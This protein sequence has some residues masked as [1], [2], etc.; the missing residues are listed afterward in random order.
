MTWRRGN[1]PNDM[2][3][4]INNN[5]PA[6]GQEF[7]KELSSRMRIVTQHMQ[8][9]LDNDVAGGG[10]PFTGKSMYFN[11]RKI[12][13]Y[14]TVNQII[15]L[16]NQTSYLKFILDPAYRHVNERKIIPY[17]NAKLTKQ[18]NITQ[19]RS[20]TQ[21]DKYKKVKSRNGNTY[22]IDATKKSSKRN[23]KLAR[24]QRVIGYY[25]S[26]G[27]KTLFDFYDE[28]EKKVIEQLRTL[29]G[30]FDYRWRN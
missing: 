28:T 27:R 14:K 18:G 12:S 9:K 22:L 8:R 24:E 4:F 20:R 29:R 23:P 2:R 3:R 26:V 11:F 15:V 10:V 19:L 1:S 5:S 7:K 30:T 16:P 6:I 13:D 25:G 21:S 17:K